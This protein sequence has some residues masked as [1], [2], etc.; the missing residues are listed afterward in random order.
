ML[1]AIRDQRGGPLG[2]VQAFARVLAAKAAAWAMSNSLRQELASQRTELLSVHAAFIDTD[3]ARG[4]PGD[5]LPA[6]DVGRPGLAAL[7]QGTRVVLV[8]VGTRA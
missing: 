5:K 1:A 3:M 7:E 8:H 4:V 6:E 2:V